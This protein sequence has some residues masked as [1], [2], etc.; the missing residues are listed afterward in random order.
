[1]LEVGRNDFWHLP[2]YVGFVVL[3]LS[4][5]WPGVR[6]EVMTIVRFDN[7]ITD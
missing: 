6:S 1:M 7:L 2:L 4:S 3:W 5:A